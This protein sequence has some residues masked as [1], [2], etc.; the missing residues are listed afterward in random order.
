MP[1]FN[2]DFL[3]FF[4]ELA[5]NNNK[6][7]FDV[8]RKRY[9]REVKVPF[10][11]FIEHMI[12]LVHKEDPKVNITYKESIFR[13][14]RDIRFSKDKTPYKTQVSGIISRGGKKD[15]VTPGIYIQL[16]P[17]HVRVYGGIFS[18]DKEQL[19]DIR[20]YILTHGNDFQ[21]AYKNKTFVDKFG[22]IRGERNKMI[23]KEFRE[24]G[25][26]EELI[27]NKQFYYFGQMEPEVVLDEKL[28]EMIMSYYRAS[29]PVKDFLEK[30]L[31]E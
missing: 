25:E 23:P 17:E 2:Q 13:I 24:L 15:K 4:K 9:E 1:Y 28:P 31:T 10:Q 26:K 21:K 20:S 22:E 12:S 11:K 6:D 3:D 5:G 30:A 18:C 19:Y 29:E 7:W 8:N 14:N 16:T 27:Y